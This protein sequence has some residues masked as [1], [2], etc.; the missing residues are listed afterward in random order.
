MRPGMGRDMRAVGSYI[1]GREMGWVA[2]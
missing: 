2:Q 1:H